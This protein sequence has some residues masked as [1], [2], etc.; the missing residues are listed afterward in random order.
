MDQEQCDTYLADLE[1]DG[2]ADVAER[3]D[4][5][6][7]FF[8]EGGDVRLWSISVYYVVVTLTTCAPSR[9]CIRHMHATTAA[10]LS[11]CPRLLN[12][13]AAASSARWS[14]HCPQSLWGG[15]A[16]GGSACMLAVR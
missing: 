9:M 2:K 6:S 16:C 1:A 15:H 14:P 13:A 11:L 12:V 3:L 7:L 4:C 8:A 10:S 5:A